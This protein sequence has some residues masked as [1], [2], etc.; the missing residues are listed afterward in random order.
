MAKK[1]QMPYD[2]NGNPVQ[3]MKLGDPEEIDGTLAHDETAALEGELVRIVALD[4][5][6][7]FLIGTAP[8]AEATSHFLGDHQEIWM[9]I[10]TGDKVSVYGGKAQVAVAGV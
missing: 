9:P 4:G 10:T 3:A 5:D 8:E 6:I 1:L 7:R 2:T